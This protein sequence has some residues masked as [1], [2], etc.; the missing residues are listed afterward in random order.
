MLTNYPIALEDL[1]DCESCNVVKE[2]SAYILTFL[3][4][5]RKSLGGTNSY[6]PAPKA[7]EFAGCSLQLFTEDASML[8]RAAL[9]P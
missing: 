2:L 9:M 7:A 4:E 8:L 5:P 3:K 6:T 1:A